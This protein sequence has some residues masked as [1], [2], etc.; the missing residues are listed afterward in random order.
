MSSPIPASL[1]TVQEKAKHGHRSTLLSQGL[2]LVCKAAGVL[3]LARLV[4]PSEQGLFAMAASFTLLLWMFR[5]MGLGSATVQNANLSEGLCTA[6]LWTQI[7][8]GLA[9][10]LTTAA[11]APFVARFYGQ[12]ALTSL[13]GSMSVSF[14][15]IGIG[16]LPRS[17]LVRELRFRELN[18]LESISAV[19]GTVAMIVAAVLGA[20]AYAFV[21][22][23]LV[24]EFLCAALAWMHCPWR[25]RVRAQCDGLL[26]LIRTGL[27][28]TQYNALNY[29]TQLIETVAVGQYL[30]AFT[31]GLYNRSG[32][33]LALPMAHVA[34]PL[35]QISLTALS[36]VT[37]TSSE[38]EIQSSRSANIIAHLTLPIAAF[39]VAAPEEV[40]HI[41]LGSQWAEAAPILRWLA[42]STAITQI[43]QSAQSVAV[44][45]GQSKRLIQTA[46]V[47]FPIVAFA[48]ALGLRQGAVGVAMAVALTN[49]LLAVPRLWW[50]LR[51]SPVSVWTYLKAIQLPLLSS[52]MLGAG[53]AL[54]RTFIFSGD[55]PW[56]L[57][58]SLI[59]A[60]VGVALA[61][62]I[63]PSLRAEWRVVWA[64][65]PW[66]T[67][68]QP[69][70]TTARDDAR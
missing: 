10:T 68:T 57:L 25:P 62:L 24:W 34:E 13:L 12:P 58:G 70:S 30:G 16:G 8:I 39:A 64:H 33:M 59:G 6:L 56:R 14:L 63:S 23:L 38:F 28:L 31:L 2:R 67:K 15:F 48:V 41:V 65:L 5:D 42:V 19:T 50:R 44:A 46:L 54:G 4:L 49:L 21:V 66:A 27:N 18:R 3:V 51:G 60:G 47:A 35:S 43:I 32:Q 7:G 52:A 36:R 37:P 17:L 20:G 11:A 26:A 9:L 1:E 29:I 69:T 53:T 45:A 22:F 40:V 61:G 55:F